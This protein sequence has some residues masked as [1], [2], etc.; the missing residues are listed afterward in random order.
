MSNVAIT[1]KK[2]KGSIYLNP[3][4]DFTDTPVAPFA[5]ADDCK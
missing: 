4:I 2:E 1:E 3:D 5:F